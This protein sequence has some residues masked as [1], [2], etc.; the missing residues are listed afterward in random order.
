MAIKAAREGAGVTPGL[1]RR[2]ERA[3]RQKTFIREQQEAA[4]AGL[5]VFDAKEDPDI[6]GT[7]I[8]CDRS[9]KACNQC[10]TNCPIFAVVFV[11]VSPTNPFCRSNS[12]RHSSQIK[13]RPRY[14]S[15]PHSQSKRVSFVFWILFKWSSSTSSCQSTSKPGK[16]SY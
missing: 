1:R 6:H 13:K 16:G 15:I 9:Y 8:L 3:E 10:L 2:R 5:R 7:Y 12:H 4:A 14:A 11:F